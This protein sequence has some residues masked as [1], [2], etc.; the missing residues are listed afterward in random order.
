MRVD[1][2]RRARAGSSGARG[3]M[4]V[5]FFF[6]FGYGGWGREGEQAVVMWAVAAGPV[7]RG[8]RR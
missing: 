7:R 8:R 4:V 5:T 1:R 3:G 2:R 6:L